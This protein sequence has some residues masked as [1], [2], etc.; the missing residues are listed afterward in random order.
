[1]EN[2][3]AFAGLSIEEK[4]VKLYLSQ[5]QLLDAFLERNAISKQQYEKSLND[6]TEKMNMEKYR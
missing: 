6:L 3:N 5:K 4:R 2:V 1:M